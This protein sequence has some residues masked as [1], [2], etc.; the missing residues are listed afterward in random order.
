[1]PSSAGPAA[2]TGGNSIPQ[3][4]RAI[5]GVTG[6]EPMQEHLPPIQ[7]RALTP[8]V[9]AVTPAAPDVIAASASVVNLASTEKL[10][11]KP[12]KG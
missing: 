3:S 7:S 2:G 11:A 1:L 4:G 6:R 10:P 12:L 8:P 9:S 5:A